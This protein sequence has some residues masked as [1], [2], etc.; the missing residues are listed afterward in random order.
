MCKA[1]LQGKPDFFC[2][3]F[4]YVLD[5]GKSHWLRLTEMNYS[6]SGVWLRYLGFPTDTPP[7][8]YNTQSSECGMTSILVRRLSAHVFSL[9]PI[10]N[11]DRTHMQVG[12]LFL[13]Q[14]T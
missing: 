1:L 3:I 13:I 12:W 4:P 8:R 7:D 9:V 2:S 14:H 5:S 11:D 6:N 10:I